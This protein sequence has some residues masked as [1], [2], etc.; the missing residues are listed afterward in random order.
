MRALRT[1]CGDFATKAGI[2]V[3]SWEEL[4]RGGV[5]GRTFIVVTTSS[6]MGSTLDSVPLG[7][8][9]SVDL[10]IGPKT[11]SKLS[12]GQIVWWF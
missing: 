1:S 9:R 12:D 5:G 8:M 3:E 6:S 2:L 11:E 4:G 10:V 7:G